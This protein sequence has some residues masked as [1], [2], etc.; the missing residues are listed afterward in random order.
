MRP[1]QIVPLVVATA[2][3]MENTDSTVIATAL[4]V[5][6]KSLG[7]DPI[8]LKLALTSYLVSLAIFIPVSGWAADR[9]GARTVFRA[10]LCVFMAGSLACA[11][12]S[13]LAGFVA[14]RFLQ[15][16][17]GAMMVPVGRLV[18]LRSVPKS[19]LVGA[20]AYLTIPALMGPVLG[21]PVG[22]FITTYFDWRW[23][24]FINI[25]IGLAGI[26]LA[27]IFFENVR[28]PERPPLD[29]LGFLLSGAGL[30]LLMLGLASTG[31]HLLPDWLSWGSVAFGAVLL[32]AYFRHS[33]GVANPVIRLDLLKHGTFRA[34]VTGGSLF[35]IGT[36][37]IPFL[38]PL[39]LQIGFGLDP[40]RSGLITFASALG[41]LL[42]K[43]IG[44]RILRL[45][46]FRRVML[47]NALIA[48]AFLAL[49]GLF[50]AG[51]PHWLIVCAL[52]F[53]GCCRS[54]QFTCV[55]AIAYAD[56]DTREMSAATS[57][58]SV[59]QQISL[60]LGVTIGALALETSARVQGHASITAADFTPAFFTVAL[61][62]AAAIFSFARLAPDAGAEVSGQ[63][64][65][66]TKP[67]DGSPQTLGPIT[68]L[69][70]SEPGR[71]SA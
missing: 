53:G 23:I 22:G 2:L 9:Y 29:V 66:A 68:P 7:E 4:P 38:L 54:L 41:A 47:S 8:A 46:G 57:L 44:P 43:I 11:G 15:G 24:F 3:F 36:G 27:T 60:S 65:L 1:S 5:I 51:T 45:Y 67:G 64:V 20:L 34:S 30:A 50:T 33:R 35:R 48:S 62:S 58:A 17:G 16:M 55:N 12:S 13:S 56:L 69:H 59:A 71:P 52:L 32:A 63:K 70:A 37:A 25:P 10:A 6:A 14:A 18:I 21:P 49:N 31:R 42:I 39:M 61:I 28:E 26:A 19:E 40:L